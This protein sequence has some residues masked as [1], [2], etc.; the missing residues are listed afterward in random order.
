MLSELRPF[1]QQIFLRAI[2][3]LLKPTGKLIFAD[4]F[5]P[6]GIARI[7]FQIKRWWYKRQ[8][9]KKSTGETHPLKWFLSYLDPIGYII[10]D[11]KIFAHG[12]IQAFE[13]KKK[14]D[15]QNPGY[16]YPPPRKSTGINAWWRAF[17]C[18][19]TGQKDHIAIEPGVYH[20]GSPLSSSPVI[21][22]A[23]YEYTYYRLMRDLRNVDA[24]VLCVDS[25]GINVWCAARGDD[26]G[27]PQLIEAVNAT[28]LKDHISHHQ[29]ILPQLSA[30][31]VSIPT[32]PKSFPFSIKY[33]PVWSKLL[34]KYLQEKPKNKPLEM[35][36]AIFNWSKRIEAGFTHVQFLLRQFLFWPSIM[37]LFLLVPLYFLLSG[38]GFVIIQRLLAFMSW[39]WVGTILTGWI[40]AILFP[41][42]NYTPLFIKKGI[43]FGII[44]SVFGTILFWF[45][46]NS[47]IYLIPTS[48]FL[49]WL[50][51]FSTMSFSGYT[52]TSSPNNIRKEYPMF[53]K[54]HKIFISLSLLLY[55]AVFSWDIWGLSI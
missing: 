24:W 11:Q 4:E 7:V 47:W 9:K 35:R 54:I 14:I 21:V 33:G 5:Y 41:L 36:L 30:G 37:L 20:S 32:L 55:I 42:T 50:G 44:S 22:T 8:L 28:D 1:E 40:I 53:V 34:P 31:G 12:A 38:I 46:F 27:N 45:I 17:K 43:V 16:Y 25:R 10:Q 26:F 49:F 52:M 6:T 13:V 19:L 48:L 18:L 23:N 2:F 15:Q 51:F 29:L 39:I 3:P